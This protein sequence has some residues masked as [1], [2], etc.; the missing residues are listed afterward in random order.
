MTFIYHR[1]ICSNHSMW[2][3]DLLRGKLW[4]DG[5]SYPHKVLKQAIR[6]K[7]SDQ[8]FLICFYPTLALAI[9]CESRD[10]NSPTVLLRVDCSLLAQAGFHCSWD[11]G[12]TEGEA[13]LFWRADQ[14][15]SLNSERS[16]AGISIDHVEILEG[17]E[18]RTVRESRAVSSRPTAPPRAT[19]PLA[20][21]YPKRAWWKFWN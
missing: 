12:F 10:F 7:P 14:P 8:L 15:S 1:S 11:D 16:S 20:Q 6:S 19:P 21:R 13:L 18:W 2:D 9:S 17:Q 3:D 4:T 5:K